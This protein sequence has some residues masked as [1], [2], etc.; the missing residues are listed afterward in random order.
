MYF[1]YSLLNDFEEV[2]LKNVQ[3]YI[4]DV[5][6]MGNLS[7]SQW[8]WNDIIKKNKNKNKNEIQTFAVTNSVF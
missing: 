6:K 2:I 5:Y 8:N 3:V 1:L 4:L 7:S